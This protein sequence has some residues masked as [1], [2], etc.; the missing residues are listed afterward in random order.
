LRRGGLHL[1]E[2]DLKVYKR[3]ADPKGL[4]FSVFSR[5]GFELLSPVLLIRSKAPTKGLASRLRLFGSRHA[6]LQMFC[7]ANQ[8]LGNHFLRIFIGLVIKRFPNIWW[9]IGCN[10]AIWR[11]FICVLIHERSGR[12]SAKYV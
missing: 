12:K 4:L 10:C 8:G 3:T 2:G 9:R 11:Q 5:R 1:G 7:R 6:S